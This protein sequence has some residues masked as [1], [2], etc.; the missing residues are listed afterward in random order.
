MNQNMGTNQNTTSSTGTTGVS[1][2]G[3]TSNVAG[4]N[5]SG[6]SGVTSG[7]TSGVTTGTVG[8]GV[9]Q[10]VKQI[11]QQLQTLQ[12]QLRQTQTS[13]A[14]NAVYVDAANR[15][16]DVYEILNKLS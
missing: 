8:V 16:Q 14:N 13:G 1:G 5:L 2:T 4:S 10:N 9:T 15:I 3:F 11:T 6:T 12:G 7:M